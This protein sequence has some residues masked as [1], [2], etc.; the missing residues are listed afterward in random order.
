[1]E[2]WDLNAVWPSASLPAFTYNEWE[3][4]PELSDVEAQRYDFVVGGRY[5]TAGGV[6]FQLSWFLSKYDDKDP[7]LEDE[8]GS[9]SS[10]LALISKSF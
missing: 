10:I 2:D 6:G 9:Y 4:V 5:R 8:T 1:M 3:V 7:I